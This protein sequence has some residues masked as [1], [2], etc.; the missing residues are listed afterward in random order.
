MEIVYSDDNLLVCV[1]PAGMLSTDV[2]GGVPEVLRAQLGTENI[3]TVH[4][5]DAAVG[6]LMLLAKRKRTAGELGR[7]IMEHG[8]HKEYLAVIKGCPDEQSGRMCDFLCRDRE[9]RMSFV[10][11][12]DA[13]NVQEAVLDYEVMAEKEGLCLVRICLHTGRTH[14]IRVQ[15]SSRGMPLWG[16]KKYGGGEEGDIALWSSRLSFT[17]PKSGRKMDMELLPDKDKCP[18]NK[19]KEELERWI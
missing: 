5:L 2:S 19:F 7:Q 1:K 12:P 9:K 15:F 10:A 6:G 8:M 3:R 16:D 14:Q 11:S 13:P 17:H 18:W 4:R